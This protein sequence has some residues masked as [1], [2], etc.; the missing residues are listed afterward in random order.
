[1]LGAPSSIPI[2]ADL[3]LPDKVTGSITQAIMPGVRLSGTVEWTNWSRLQDVAIDGFPATLEFEWKDGW[4]FAIGGE[5]DYSDKLTLRTGFGYEISPIQDPGAR[6]VQLPDNDRYWLSAGG[7]Y[8]V[9]DMM[10]LLKD[11][12]VDF[13]YS[14]IF[15]E[16]GDFVRSP[17]ADALSVISFSGTVDASVDI[18]SIGIRSK[19]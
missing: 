4:Y 15:V 6:L 18:I 5:Y 7:T 2:G 14:H 8:K 16:D 3:D 12:E 19:L 1:V 17:A 10:G 11:A 13:A 9:G